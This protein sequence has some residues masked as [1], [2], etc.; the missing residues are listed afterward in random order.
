M[1]DLIPVGPAPGSDEDE[2]TP[3]VGQHVVI[4][5]RGDS[6]RRMV[7]TG[8]RI[9]SM[10][11]EIGHGEVVLRIVVAS[12]DLIVP[13]PDRFDPPRIGGITVKPRGGW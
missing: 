4:E 8:C 10:E 11:R 12:E 6:G 1:S 5:M 3:R 7:F 13:E 2:N 9:V